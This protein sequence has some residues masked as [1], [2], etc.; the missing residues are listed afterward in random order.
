MAKKQ[1][2]KVS[3]VVLVKEALQ[4]LGTDAEPVAVAEWV[5]AKKGAALAPEQVSRIIHNMRALSVNE[6]LSF[7]PGAGAK[8]AP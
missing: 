7:G 8:A 1:E 6:R 2:E 3:P 4:A 5:G